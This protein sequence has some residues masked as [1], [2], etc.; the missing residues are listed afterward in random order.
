MAFASTPVIS[1][2]T[3]SI[4]PCAAAGKGQRMGKWWTPIFGWSQEPDYFDDATT[5][6][7]GSVQEK[8]E[9][10]RKFSMFTEEKARELRM[11]TAETSTF[12]EVMYHSAIASRLASDFNTKSQDV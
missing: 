12:H 3:P 11:K 8:K 6:D 2:R 4:R 5:D 7:D 1:F 10:H 9:T